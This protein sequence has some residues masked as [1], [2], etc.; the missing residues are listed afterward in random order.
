[1]QEIITAFPPFTLTP[2]DR[3]PW[4]TARTGH[5][6]SVV[7]WYATIAS[8]GGLVATGLVA[9]APTTRRKKVFG[10]LATISITVSGLAVGSTLSKNSTATTKNQSCTPRSDPT[11]P[12][13]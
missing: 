3:R 11:D 4:T 13:C 10:V 12:A 9:S 6:T 7:L 5:H 2:P 8:F 1:V